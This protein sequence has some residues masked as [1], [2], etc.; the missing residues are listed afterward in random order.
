MSESVLIPIILCGGS[1]SR[2]WP[3]S[4][5]SFPKQFI[6]LLDDEDS[7]LQS[8]QKRISGIKNIQNPI[9]ICNENHRF[10]VAEQMREINICPKAIIL[11]P[12]G[13]NTAP[14]VTL[15]ALRA[16]EE[17]E[18]AILLVL[19]SDHLIRDIKRFHEVINIGKNYAELEKLVTFGIVPTTPETGYGYIKSEKEFNT[20]EIEGLKISEF[21]EKP[22]LKFAK[23]FIKN[24]RFT[25]NS[26]MFM[27]KAEVI[28]KEIKKFHPEIYFACQ[29]SINKKIKDLDFERINSK[30][31]SKSPQ[32]SIDNAVME[33]TAN[34]TVLP[35]SAGWTDIGNWK[36]VW[37]NSP[38]DKDGNSSKGKI[39]TKNSKN[40]YL[41]SD[42]KLLVGLGLEDILVIDTNDAILI[43]NSTEA[44]TVKDIVI[45]L[46]QKNISEGKFQKKVY[47]PWGNYISLVEGSHWQVKMIYVKPGAKLSLQF[48]QYRAEHWIIVRG[49][50][51][52]EINKE[53]QTLK[54][55]QSTYIP[56]KARHRLSNPGEV[57]LILIEVQSGNY[58]GEDDIIRIEDEYGR[59][60]ELSN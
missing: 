54:E 30:S 56:I 21:I 3:L 58:L 31:F 18:D 33:K 60:D 47:R 6:S 12:F 42:N 2:L 49:T 39:I 20:Q 1:G 55:N 41:R 25:W 29:E 16:I 4:R 11:E 28:L 35:L 53:K 27:F 17:N 57:P 34:G 10:I 9:L 14:A 19:S 13:R 23:E 51:N 40:C 48:H 8:T 46:N 36:S 22:S 24:K 37:E 15:G 7:L 59:E 50:A 26:G 52:I 5:E 32:I 38:K 45:E 43:A 44:Q